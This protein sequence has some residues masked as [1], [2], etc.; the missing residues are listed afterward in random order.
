MLGF[1]LFSQCLLAANEI[2]I[3]LSALNRWTYFSASAT[4]INPDD[5]YLCLFKSQMTDVRAE[6]AANLHAQVRSEDGCV[7]ISFEPFDKTV[8]IIYTNGRKSVD[9]LRFL[10]SFERSRKS[11]SVFTAVMK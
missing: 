9:I 1:R 2:V 10:G 4:P 8:G 3:R 5:E 7:K 11:D 6:F